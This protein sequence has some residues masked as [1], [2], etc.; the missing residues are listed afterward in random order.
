MDSIFETFNALAEPNR[1]HIVE[2]L[3]EQ[4]MPVGKIAEKLKIKQPQVSKHLQVLSNAGLVKVFPKAQQRIYTL[5]S[6][7]FKKLD[8]WI[9]SYNEL[10]EKKFNYLD[11]FL[12]EMKK[13]EAKN[14]GKKR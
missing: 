10:W 13:E 9:E 7:P 5:Q 1:F 2:L 8:S 12:I 6:K 4:P 3:H 14:V 11:K